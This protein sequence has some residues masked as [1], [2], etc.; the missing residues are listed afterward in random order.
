MS[1]LYKKVRNRSN[2]FWVLYFLNGVTIMPFVVNNGVHV[3]I[4]GLKGT[5]GSNL[6]NLGERMIFP[7]EQP[8]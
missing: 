3:T 2:S 5:L 6:I 4:S 8:K 1:A 7:L